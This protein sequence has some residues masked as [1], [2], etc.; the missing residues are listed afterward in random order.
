MWQ[1]EDGVQQIILQYH[2]TS[3]SA[4][5]WSPDGL[6][7][8]SGDFSGTVCLWNH[9]LKKCLVVDQCLSRIMALQFSRD[10]SILRVADDGTATL[11]CPIPYVFKLCNI[12]KKEINLREYKEG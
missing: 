5:A 11:N 7:L 2:N 4:L 6:L 3:I 12:Y 10:A 8:A 9:K 1:R